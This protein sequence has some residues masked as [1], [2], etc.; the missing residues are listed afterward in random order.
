MPSYNISEIC[1]IVSG[2]LFGK[3]DNSVENLL[4]DSR[5]L[6]P[7]D[8]TLFFAIAGK[9][10]DGHNYIN[11]MYAKGVRCFIVSRKIDFDEFSNSSFILVTN[12]IEALQKIAEYH[13]NKNNIEV[14]GITGSNGKTVVKEWISQLLSDYLRIVKNPKSY[15]SQIGVPLSVWAIEKEHQ[16]GIFEAGISQID[17]MINLERIIKPTIGIFTNI[18]DAHQENFE[19]T[20]Q[21]IKQKLILFK[22]CK[23]L[24]YCN[25]YSN[26]N[27]QINSNNY[28]LAKTISWGKKDA[29]YLIKKIEKNKT[30]TQIEIS[31]NKEIIIFEIPFS[32]NASIENILHAVVFIHSQYPEIKINILNF[33][34]LSHLEMRMEQL[35]AVN[36][37]TL[38]N[39]SYSCDI[40][41]LKIA[42]DQLNL[43]N[44]HILKTLILSDIQ[45]VNTNSEITYSEVSK[46]VNKN[47]ISKFI[48]IGEEIS[49]FKNL[50][51]DNSLFFTDTKAF[52]N[53]L[54]V[55]N[56]I[57]ED[58][59]LKGARKFTFEKISNALQEKNHRTVLEINLEALIH[60]LNF[61]RSQ[62]KPETKIMV[63]VKAFSY[64]SGSY[65][66]ANL[67]QNQR[68]DY[69]GVAVADEGVDLRKNGINIPI[70]IMN[71]EKNSFY[72]II[73]NNLE[74]E[75]Y[76]FSVLEEFNRAVEKF[77][78]HSYPIH[79]KIDSGMHRLGFLE[80]QIDELLN[81]LKKYPKLKIRS[82]FSHLAG[83]SDGIHDKYTQNQINIFTIISEKIIQSIGY[84]P[85]L[86]ILN[87]GGIE[88]WQSAQFDM[89]RLGIGLYGVSS[90]QQDKLMNIS[91]LKTTISQI[92]YLKKGETVGYSRKGILERDSTIAIIPIGYAD[93]FNRKLS[94]RVGK[95][96]INNQ[97]APIIGNICMDLSMID[98]TDIEANEGDEVIIFGNNFTVS[99]IA[100]LIGTIPYEVLTGISQRVKRV[101][102][103]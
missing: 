11:D 4:I 25:D 91:T 45:E 57:N 8:Y 48:G 41:S 97:F 58:I 24:I 86:H 93:G 70:I 73:E 90:Y 80:N 79:I 44:K 50:F 53:S 62:L 103:K 29:D 54:N 28:L 3:S 18:G 61:F 81:D 46:I 7:S 99:D 55:N 77:S 98:I 43:L 1:T 83:S 67:L 75:I 39:D 101:Y 20:D 82:V 17:E 65:E 2:K 47:N 84:K 76:S 96:I 30:V 26:I 66:I 19:S 9:N 6:I 92:K 14:L 71:P 34:N 59:L 16:L 64:G 74:P 15:N 36:N 40:S 85:M 21:K 22:N 87:S 33:K 5:I 12:T 88:R 63:M 89:V 32:D 13:R 72:K 27:I 23:T 37:C 51:A 78:P 38:I 56:F 60:N 69:L 95:V 52:L 42:L 102:F 49:K 35:K 94:N 100:D 10:H 68:V 31:V